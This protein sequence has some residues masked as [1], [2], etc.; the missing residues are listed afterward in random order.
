[1]SDLDDSFAN[2]LGRQPSDAER[3]QLYKVRDAL[4]LKNNDA[5]WLV[6]MALQHYQWQYE[7]FPVMIALAAKHTLVDFKATADAAAKASVE[8]AKADL[9]KAVA[10]VARE[11]ARRVAGTE[12][13]Q[14]MLACVLV[15]F[16]AFGGFGWYMH[17]TAYTAGFN[18]GYG[19]GYTEAKDEK[20]AA[21][22]ANTPEGKTAYRMAKRGDIGRLSHCERPG[23]YIEDGVCYVKPDDKGSTYGWRVP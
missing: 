6:M 4:G 16:F 2:L 5:L 12:M 13:T 22:W 19:S 17:R 20:A 1:M 18:S 21:A 14:W 8:A 15:A 11:V 3:Q 10:T 9:A 23:W 7:K